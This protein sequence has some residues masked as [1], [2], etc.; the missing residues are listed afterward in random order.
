[1]ASEQTAAAKQTQTTA[2]QQR[3]QPQ[4]AE[5]GKAVKLAPPELPLALA[6]LRE[7][8]SGTVFTLQRKSGNR[9]IQRLIQTKLTV[10]PVE[11]EE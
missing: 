10:G 2:R 7:A 8:R 9:A 6:D 3:P 11:Q 1:M 4:I 5:G